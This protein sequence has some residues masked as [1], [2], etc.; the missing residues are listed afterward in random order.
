MSEF[1]RKELLAQTV[2]EIWYPSSLVASR[3][4]MERHLKSIQDHMAAARRETFF[5]VTLVSESAFMAE[6]FL[7]FL[8]AISLQKVI[9]ENKELF[10]ETLRR[11]WRAKIQHLPLSS[12]L[13]KKAPDLGDAR[14]RDAGKLFAL[15]NRIAHSYP[16]PDH[17]GA[18]V[19]YFFRNYPVLEHPMPFDG[20][21]MATQRLLP[22]RDEALE[23]FSAG[24]GL[25]QF[26]E[27]IDEG[28]RKVFMLFANCSPLGYRA[29]TGRYVRVFS[30]VMAK[31]FLPTDRA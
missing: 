29:D 14:V 30:D 18:G 23:G 9:R 20:F 2:P 22:T 7:N 27:E 13:V 10:E 26:I 28:F 6:A 5:S 17:L 1:A 31:A 21:Q 3:A 16:D 8:L 11:T 19:M 12:M 4:D 25:V 24:Q 15:R